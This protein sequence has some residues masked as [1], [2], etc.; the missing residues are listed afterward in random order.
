VDVVVVIAAEAMVI[1]MLEFLLMI[2]PTNTLPITDT[3][4]QRLLSTSLFHTTT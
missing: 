4:G 1:A 3:N 2:R